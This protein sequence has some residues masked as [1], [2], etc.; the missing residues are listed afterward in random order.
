[1]NTKRLYLKW[2]REHPAFY[3]LE[4]RAVAVHDSI[5]I[6]FSPTPPEDSYTVEW[7]ATNAKVTFFIRINFHGR[8]FPPGS[9]FVIDFDPEALAGLLR[10]P[11][12]SHEH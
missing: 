8:D 9:G 2:R 11:R 3:L 4:M 5:G 6:S 10:W 12:W 7:G 1:M